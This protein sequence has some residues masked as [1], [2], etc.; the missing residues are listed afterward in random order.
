MLYTKINLKWIKNINVKL[1]LL[2][3][4]LGQA[5]WYFKALA[6][7]VWVSQAT[8]ALIISKWRYIKLKSFCKGNNQQNEKATHRKGKQLQNIYVRG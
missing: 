3:E 7:I 5:P 6:M 2:K 8:K 1:K 4:N